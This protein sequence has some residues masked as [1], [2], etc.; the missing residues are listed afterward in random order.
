MFKVQCDITSSVQSELLFEVAVEVSLDSEHLEKSSS[1][2]NP[3][4]IM[5][6]NINDFFAEVI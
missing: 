4:E 3:L 5:V 2:R 1:L 6:G